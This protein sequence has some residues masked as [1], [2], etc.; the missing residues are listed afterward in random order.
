M[1]DDKPEIPWPGHWD[2]PGGGREGRE[3]PLD[4]ALRETHEELG[5]VIDPHA[6]RW[7]RAFAKGASYDWFFAGHIAREAAAQITF[8][9]EGQRWT[10]MAPADYAVHPKRIPHFAERIGM[11]LDEAPGEP[12]ERP[13]AQGG[14]R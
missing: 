13:P 10:L 1:R 11:Y 5:L 9:D 14:G 7:G 4:C 3:T 6:V 12:F 2:L 8:G